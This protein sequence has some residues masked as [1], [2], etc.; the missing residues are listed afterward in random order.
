[1]HTV[2][3]PMIGI[4]GLYFSFLFSFVGA[5]GTLAG[6]LCTVVAV[7]SCGAVV[8]AE[9][10]STQSPWGASALLRCDAV[11]FPLRGTLCRREAAYHAPQSPEVV[12]Q[13]QLVLWSTLGE[14]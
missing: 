2:L 7:R 11:V 5:G 9:E 13:L 6:V 3:C 12:K 10:R 1:M 4:A 14:Q 8:I